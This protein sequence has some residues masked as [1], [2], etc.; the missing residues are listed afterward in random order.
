MG[1]KKKEGKRSKIRKNI[2]KIKKVN[3]RTGNKTYYLG[4]RVKDTGKAGLDSISECE[5]IAK[6]IYED[7][8]AGRLIRQEANGRFA[9]L[10]NTIIPRRFSGKKRL[11]A[12][13][14][15]KKW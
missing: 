12:Q 1:R 3:P 7:Y 6:K 13:E 15:V 10:H 2:A 5:R 11:E 4:W 9:L 8:K 14:A